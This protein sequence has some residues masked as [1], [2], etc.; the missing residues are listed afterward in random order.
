MNGVNAELVTEFAKDKVWEENSEVFKPNNQIYLLGKQFYRMSRCK[1]KVNVIVTDSPL[2][3][4]ILYNK[5]TVLSQSFN[6]VVME[7]EQITFKPLSLR[8]HWAQFTIN[9]LHW[10]I[11]CM[12]TFTIY[13][14]FGNFL[15]HEIFLYLGIFLVLYL[16]YQVLYLARMEYIIT[17]DQII[18][19]HGVISHSTDY[20]ELYRVIDYQQHRSLMQQPTGLKTVVIYSGDRNTP[21]MQLVGMEEKDDVVKEIRRRVEYNKQLKHIYEITN[22]M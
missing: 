5:S 20:M 18:F 6:D 10:L 21:V 1:D 17:S 12:V 19:L 22:R 4:S 2:P 3:L 14:C 9:Q 11:L 7:K 15:F 8:P 13:C 16:V